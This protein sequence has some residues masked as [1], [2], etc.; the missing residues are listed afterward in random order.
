MTSIA[1]VIGELEDQPGQR[2]IA[3]VGDR[4][5]ADLEDDGCGG[6]LGGGQDAL[7]RLE[8]ADVEGGD[9]EPLGASRRVQGPAVDPRHG[10]LGLR[11]YIV[12]DGSGRVHRRVM[13][14]RSG[15]LVAWSRLVLAVVMGATIGLLGAGRPSPVVA[16][17][18]PSRPIWPTIAV[19]DDDDVHVAYDNADGLGLIYATNSSGS[20]VRKRITNGDDRLPHLVVDQHD[21]VHIIFGRTYS[22]K[23]RALFYTTNRSGS[24]VT[25]KLPWVAPA[26]TIRLAIAPEFGSSTPCTRPIARCTTRPTMAVRGRCSGWTWTSGPVRS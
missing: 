14:R 2:P 13:V 12:R 19:D 6:R 18:S 17:T 4:A 11:R 26:S 25:T 5:G 15:S 21:K 1:A 16:D 9:G 22:D 23:P 8:V 7:R 10:A 24:W 3:G 20:W